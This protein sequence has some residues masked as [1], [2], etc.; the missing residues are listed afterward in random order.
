[1]KNL[2]K[3]Q[4]NGEISYKEDPEGNLGVGKL[5]GYLD[6]ANFCA[7]REHVLDVG[8]GPQKI[9]SHFE[10]FEKSNITFVGVDPLEGEQ[11]RD[12]IFFKALGEHLPFKD[13]IFDQVLFTTSL[14]HFLD[15]LIALLEAKRVVKD[16]GEIIVLMGD[17]VKEI[18]NGKPIITNDWYE[19]LKVPEG[20]E[21]RFHFWEFSLKDFEKL[22]YKASLK[23]VDTQ[24]KTI[25]NWREKLVKNLINRNQFGRIA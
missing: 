24:R 8:V 13:S 14:D 25:R 20:A 1:M 21:D 2:A 11:P 9:P 4:H 19:A 10:G 18:G 17:K 12:F 23:I 15:P 22:A 16:G 6:F 7:F 5:K 3:L